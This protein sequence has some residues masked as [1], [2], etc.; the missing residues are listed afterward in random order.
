M[1]YY[2]CD[3]CH[4]RIESD[5]L[6]FIVR[7]EAYAALDP[8]EEGADADDRDHLLE[9]HETLEQLDP[10]E[11]PL[12]GEGDRQELCFDLCPECHRKYTKDPLGRE[13]SKHLSFSKN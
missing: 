6:R 4:R 13:L 11:E 5:E 2:S 8:L 9:I 1:I 10:T 7:I 3:I 12:L